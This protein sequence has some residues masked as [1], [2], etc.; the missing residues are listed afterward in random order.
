MY[1]IPIDVIRACKAD[2]NMKR[3]NQF[4]DNDLNQAVSQ[5]KNHVAIQTLIQIM[6]ENI[7]ND[8]IQEK[9]LETIIFVAKDNISS[10]AFVDLGGISVLLNGMSTHSDLHRI[11]W[12]GCVAITTF[13][14]NN[15]A[16]CSDLRKQGVCEVIMNVLMD[17]NSPIEVKQQALWAIS[18]LCQL[19][20]AFY[21]NKL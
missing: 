14:K 1:N 2:N 5:S 12:R 13:C 21:P 10:R 11:G 4:N 9:G 15:L 17:E 3:I 19:G 18:Y 6:N 8:K 16:I 7:E 20:E